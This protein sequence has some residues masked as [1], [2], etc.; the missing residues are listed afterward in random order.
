MQMRRS[1][2]DQSI[3]MSGESG[4]GKTE[5]N[6]QLMLYLARHAIGLKLAPLAQGAAAFHTHR[7]ETSMS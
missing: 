2:R 4:A 7:V 5:S 6:K 3:C 1:G